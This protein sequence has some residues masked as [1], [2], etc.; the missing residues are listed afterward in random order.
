MVSAEISMSVRT[1]VLSVSSVAPIFGVP[2]AVT[3]TL[4]IDSRQTDDRVKTSMN[5]MITMTSAL[6]IV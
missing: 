6:E 5:V 2:I 3:A 4:A 1:S